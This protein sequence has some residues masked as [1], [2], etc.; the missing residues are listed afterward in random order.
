MMT[1]AM[2]SQGVRRRIGVMSSTVR[3]RVATNGF[4]L[5]NNYVRRMLRAV[6][7]EQ[8]TLLEKPAATTEKLDT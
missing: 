2:K 4:R 7:S 6:A 8:A 1:A 3:P 5:C